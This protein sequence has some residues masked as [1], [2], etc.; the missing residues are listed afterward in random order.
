MFKVKHKDTGEIIQVLDTYLD[1]L[2]HK[3]Y[4]LTWINGMWQ[5]RNADNYIP[6][7]YTE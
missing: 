6:P 4:F 3:T 5:W 7:N 1:M 2:Y